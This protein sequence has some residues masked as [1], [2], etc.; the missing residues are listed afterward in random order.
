MGIK[1]KL[2]S[3]FALSAL[4]TAVFA[5]GPDVAPMAPV[6]SPCN[7]FSYNFYIGIDGGW[8]SLQARNELR[9]YLAP[10]LLETRISRTHQSSFAGGGVFGFGSVMPND[11]Y[12]GFEV[13]ATY[14]DFNLSP[15]APL[16]FQPASNFVQ[17]T[18]SDWDWGFDFVPGYVY[19]SHWLLFGKV[20]Y[21]GANVQLRS[22]TVNAL[23]ANFTFNRNQ[24]ANG[25]NLGIGLKYNFMT[26]VSAWIEYDY[27]AFTPLYHTFIPG[28][29]VPA[30]LN[31][32]ERRVNINNQQVLVGLSY[33]FWTDF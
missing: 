1:L 4:T 3:I 2:T 14:H 18:Y 29:Q 6:S 23:P 27:T 19:D 5:G 25:L 30:L 10:A 8:A 12:V 15:G 21:R 32:M 28:Q 22:F 11:L 20:G 13:N 9:N 16:R 24:Y 17:R 7:A 31:T 26:N 33:S